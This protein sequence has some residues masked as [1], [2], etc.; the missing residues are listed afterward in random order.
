MIN[1]KAYSALLYYIIQII[2]AVVLKCEIQKKR[3]RYI[4]IHLFVVKDAQLQTDQGGHA[5]P[6]CHIRRQLPAK[7]QVALE[8]TS[9]PIREGK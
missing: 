6:Q 1:N 3:A 4:G 5:V 9:R 7:Q 2:L 8:T